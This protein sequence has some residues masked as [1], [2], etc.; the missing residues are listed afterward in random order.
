MKLILILTFFYVAQFSSHAYA[1]DTKAAQMQ[2]PQVKA[3]A[4]MTRELVKDTSRCID[5]PKNP[6]LKCSKRT[7]V[8]RSQQELNVL[9]NRPKLKNNQYALNYENNK[10]IVFSTKIHEGLLLSE[11]C[12]KGKTPKCQAYFK[13]IQT[14]SSKPE[15]NMKSPNHNNLGAIHCELMGGKGLI[16]KTS[17]NDDSDFCQFEDGSMVSSWSAYYKTHPQSR[18]K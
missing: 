10:T 14:T 9:K 3:N 5:D 12:F 8:K 16:A 11:N 18:T 1:I 15:E 7:P 4:K 13:S 17:T 2:N 6:K